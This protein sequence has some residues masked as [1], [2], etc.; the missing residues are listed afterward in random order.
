VIE[1]VNERLTHRLR[2]ALG[3]LLPR[4]L[5]VAVGT[6]EVRSL[7]DF[8][9]ALNAPC[10]MN[11]LALPPL[12]GPGLLVFEQEL[13]FALVDAYFGGSGRAHVPLKGR[14]FTHTENRFIQRLRERVFRALEAAW[15]PFLSV[16]CAH[17]GAEVDP[18]FVTAINSEEVLVVTSLAIKWDELALSLHLALPCAAFE[19]V[20]DSLLASLSKDHPV[21]NDGLSRLLREGVKDSRVTL[22]G[23]L[24]ET[25][26][27]LGELL[28]L[29][30]GDF[31]PMEIPSRAVLEAEEVPVYAGRYGIAQGQRAMKIE[32]V[33]IAFHEGD[34]TMERTPV[35]EE[36][37]G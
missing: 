25:E 4:E 11:L 20:R 13:V 12:A 17:L 31:I 16:Q 9:G 33:L 28:A 1:T 8:R 10:S 24:A 5:E 7:G 34:A 37:A 36:T 21:R 18:Q 29:Q 22:R 32:E 26:I 35:K 27:K 3:E 30:V 6:L 2:V 19:P 15:Q 14:D 23:F